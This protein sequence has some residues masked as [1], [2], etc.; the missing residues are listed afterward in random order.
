M[1]GD[2]LIRSRADLV[3]EVMWVVLQ[4]ASLG[5]T[6]VIGLGITRRG[7]HSSR[8]PLFLFGELVSTPLAT[9]LLRC[10]S[11]WLLS[12]SSFTMLAG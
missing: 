1:L 4:D 12:R 6:K 7:L 8:T 10:W 3:S 2:G 5:S 9:T 11:A